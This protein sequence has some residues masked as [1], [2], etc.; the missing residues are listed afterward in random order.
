LLILKRMK[1]FYYNGYLSD[2]EP[3]LENFE[4]KYEVIKDINLHKL[5]LDFPKIISINVTERCI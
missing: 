4:L 1:V 5:Q 3:F 2:W